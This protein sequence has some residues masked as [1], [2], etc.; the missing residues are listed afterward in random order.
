[1][2]KVKL[3]SVVD[4]I[5]KHIV[6]YG[7]NGD[8]FIPIKLSDSQ[9]E[10]LNLISEMENKGVNTQQIDMFINSAYRRRG[11]STEELKTITCCQKNYV[12]N[13]TIHFWTQL[14]NRLKDEL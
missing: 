9:K 3:M 7:M 10:F 8:D 12:K 11:K 2:N 5:E 13:L 4:F 14:I 1:M 6:T